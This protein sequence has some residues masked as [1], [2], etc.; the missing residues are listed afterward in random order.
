MVRASPDVDFG[1]GNLLECFFFVF[2][3]V[4]FFGM[5]GL[6]IRLTLFYSTK[7]HWISQKISAAGAP[8][9]APTREAPLLDLLIWKHAT[10]F[11]RLRPCSAPS[12]SLWRARNQPTTSLSL[13]LCT[14]GS[15]SRKQDQTFFEI[16][17][18][19]L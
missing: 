16:S 9:A 19:P 12:F 14:R 8:P 15:F 4:L 11:R 5:W 10:S 3:P 17:A 6:Y 18:H 13:S 1:A 2:L 7:L